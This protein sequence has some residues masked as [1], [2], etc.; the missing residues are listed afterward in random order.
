MENEKETP[1]SI[2]ITKPTKTWFFQRGDGYVFAC[3]ENEAHGLISNRSNWARNDFRA[4]GTSNGE[5]YFK[6]I[7]ESKNIKGDL[8]AELTDHKASLKRFTDTEDRLRF[9]ELLSDEDEKVK[10]VVALR[11]A[12]IEKIDKAQTELA[13]IDANIVEKAFQ[14]E[15]E[16]ARVNGFEPPR[17]MDIITPVE[18]DRKKIIQNIA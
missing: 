5:T 18:S 1:P 2:G 13:N 10:R 9:E 6:V 17:N 14:A 12:L 16:V 15:L 7:N 8:L 4:I 11:K 3:D